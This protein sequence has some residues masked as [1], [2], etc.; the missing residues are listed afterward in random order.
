MN[1]I[2]VVL[3]MNENQSLLTNEIT[4][5]LLIKLFDKK[6]IFTKSN[7]TLNKF[8]CFILCINSKFVSQM[9]SILGSNF[10]KGNFD[11][12]THFEVS[13]IQKLHC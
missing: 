2:F 4:V 6:L 5:F 12:F 7:F 3:W 10:H 9:N 8:L 11:G 13:W 1:W